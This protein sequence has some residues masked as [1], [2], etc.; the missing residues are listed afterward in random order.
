MFKKKKER[1]YWRTEEGRELLPEQMDINHIKNCM[2]M[3]ERRIK[4][5]LAIAIQFKNSLGGEQPTR[6][7]K[8]EIKSLTELLEDP[9]GNEMYNDFHMELL[10]RGVIKDEF[11]WAD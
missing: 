9:C 4:K 1:N 8:S 10:D 11:T 6:K 7:M 2:K 5:T 3:I